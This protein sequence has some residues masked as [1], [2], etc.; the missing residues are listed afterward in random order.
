MDTEPNV[1]WR[2]LK[3]ALAN[4]EIDTVN[5]GIRATT[6]GIMANTLYDGIQAAEGQ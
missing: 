6:I 2:V 5:G 4:N 3:R 1:L